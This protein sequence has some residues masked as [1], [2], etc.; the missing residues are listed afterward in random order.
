VKHGEYMASLMLCSH[1]HWT[2]DMKTMAPAGPDKMFSGG[3]PLQVPM[4]GS[5]TL[6]TPN[7]TS[8]PDTGIGT[9]T[10]DQ[11]YTTIKTMVRP[12][13]KPILGPMM[14]MQGAWSQLDDADLRAVAAFIKSLPPVK[15]KVPASTFKPNAPADK[16]TPAKQG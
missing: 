16:P 10:E 9:W 7:I 6:F 13:G 14:F 15:N 8:D 11:I 4:L 1:C 3:L 2:P 12:S 5:G